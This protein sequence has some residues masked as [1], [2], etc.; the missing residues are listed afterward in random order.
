MNTDQ[1]DYVQTRLCNELGLARADDLYIKKMSGGAIQ[2]NWL[3]ENADLA[4]VLRKNAESSMDVSS[5]REQEFLLLVRLYQAGILVPE[6]LYFEKAPNLLNSDFF[7]MKK[8]TGSAE[9][10]KLVKQLDHQ[11][12]QTLVTTIGS[13]LARIHAV[14]PDEQLQ[15]LFGQ[16]TSADYLD[17]KIA[18]FRAQLDILQRSRPVLEYAIRWLQQN[19]PK[20]DDLVLIHGDFRTGNLMVDGDVLTGILDWEFAQWGDRREDIGWF[21]AKCWRFGQD[22]NIAG[23]IGSYKDFMQSYAEASSVYIPEFELKF[24][25]VL[26]HVRWAIIAMQQS[27]R[28]NEMQLPSLELALTEFMVPRLEKHILDLLGE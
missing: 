23:G 26:A 8:I 2:E 9:G 12:S 25:H 18:T 27:N 1:V 19:Q 20:V 7:M 15:Q 11:Q 17:C 5:S 24:W 6:P 3:L 21:T 13:Q 28:N 16:P 10:H 22:H 4:L 14:Q